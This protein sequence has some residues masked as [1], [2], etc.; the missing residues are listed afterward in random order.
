MLTLGVNCPTIQQRLL[1]ESTISLTDFINLV[2]AVEAAEA[3]QQKIHGASGTV[4][5]VNAS[6][7]RKKVEFHSSKARGRS[8]SRT[9]LQKDTCFRCGRSGRHND[10]TVCPAINS[11]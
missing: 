6:N 10:S 3:D 9:H 8:H 7:Q 1:R 4:R 2:S 11:K 5:S